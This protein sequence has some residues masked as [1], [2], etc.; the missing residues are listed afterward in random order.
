MDNQ[1]KDFLIGIIGPEGQRVVERLCKNSPELES[2]L[3]P[4]ALMSWI[5]VLS[6][7][8]KFEGSIPGVN[9]SELKFIKNNKTFDGQI[10][11]KESLSKFEN[12]SI[13]KLAATIA[14]GLNMDVEGISKGVDRNRLAVLGKTLDLITKS[15]FIA[16][17]KTDATLQL[18][19]KDPIK[20]FKT[21]PSIKKQVLL[22]NINISL[23]E[24]AKYCSI[25]G[26][27]QFNNFN[28]IGCNCLKAMAKST[29]TE[30]INNGCRITLKGKE[31]DNEALS[32]F[33]K[34]VKG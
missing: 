34:I 8:E 19:E 29:I 24:M 17:H 16:D 27:K 32:A 14:V 5:S 2:V 9:G 21:I 25:C 33:L 23:E 22:K 12:D 7:L 11:I 18:S 10:K 13:L 26:L 6:N 1:I 28:F 4:R 3:I 31:W 15:K 20:Q 30:K